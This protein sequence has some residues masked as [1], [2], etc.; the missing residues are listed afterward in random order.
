MDDAEREQPE[1]TPVIDVRNLYTTTARFSA[2]S[3]Q[4]DPRAEQHGKQA[5]H[6]PFEKQVVRR[7][8][9]EIEALGATVIRWVRIGTGQPEADNIH[10][11]D[12]EKC[13]AANCVD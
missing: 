9:G 11:Q 4:Y 2:T 6:G 5:T 10:Q 8:N 12:A 7:P 3:H 1:R 13:Y